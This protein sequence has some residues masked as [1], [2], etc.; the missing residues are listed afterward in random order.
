MLYEE[1]V[2]NVKKAA[3]KIRA[4]KTLGHT[5][6]QFN[7]YGEA[8]GAFYLEIADG[9]IF[10]EPYEYYDRDLIIVT[11][12][13]VVMQMIEGRLQPRVAFSNGL[14]EVYGDPRLLELLPLG[15]ESKANKKKTE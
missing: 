3:Q 4:S 10:V 7:I 9:K 6:F 14:L 15:C 13:D 12:A 2:D 11:T 8:E 1:L 5:A